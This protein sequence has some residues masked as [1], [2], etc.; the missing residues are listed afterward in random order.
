MT[1]RSGRRVLISR[2]KLS[3][4]ILGML[5]S[6]RVTISS[7]RTPV[8]QLIDR[9]LARG[10]EMQHIGALP[11]LAVKALTKHFGDIG[12]VD[13][14]EGAEAHASSPGCARRE[15]DRRIVKTRCTRLHGCRRRSVC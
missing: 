5:M 8:R 6:D 1:G 14:D 7:G 4:S 13:D 3:P 15:R 9:L 11:R 2:N 10:G 12:L